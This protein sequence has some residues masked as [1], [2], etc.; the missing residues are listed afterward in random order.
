MGYPLKPCTVLL[1]L[2]LP[3]WQSYNLRPLIYDYDLAFDHIKRKLQME[4]GY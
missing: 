3:T 2:L 1:G 4:W